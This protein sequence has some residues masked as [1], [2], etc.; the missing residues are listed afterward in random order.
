MLYAVLSD[1]GAKL[2]CPMAIFSVDIMRNHN[3]RLVLANE[4]RDICTAFSF[5]PVSVS[6]IQRSHINVAEISDHR[7]LAKTHMP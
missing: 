1:I 6:I 5:C 7:V 3:V 2:M 4:F